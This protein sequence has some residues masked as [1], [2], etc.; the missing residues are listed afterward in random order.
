MVNIL[1]NIPFAFI[2]RSSGIPV[3][4]DIMSQPR[5]MDA[6]RIAICLLWQVGIAIILTPLDVLGVR[7]SAQPNAH[8]TDKAHSRDRGTKDS[9]LSPAGDVLPDN[10]GEGILAQRPRGEP[11]MGMVDCARKMIREEGIGSLYKGWWWVLMGGV[12]KMM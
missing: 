3:G 7:L 2:A 9:H 11:Y 8:G 4:L 10:S 5:D 12:V 1:Q 6:R